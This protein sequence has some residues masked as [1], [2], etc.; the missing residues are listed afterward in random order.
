MQRSRDDFSHLEINYNPTIIISLFDNRCQQSVLEWFEI[1][2]YEPTWQFK[3]KNGGVVSQ[4]HHRHNS[5]ATQRS[6]AEFKRVFVHKLRT[7]QDWSDICIFQQA[8]RLLFSNTTISFANIIQCL[9]K[10]FSVNDCL[11][12]DHDIL[13][14]CKRLL[15][16]N[17]ALYLALR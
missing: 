7:I 9:F 8:P 11:I 2:N 13:A 1:F 10:R 16:Q 4:T 17:P 3:T 14:A 12:A 15:E 6:I 5:K